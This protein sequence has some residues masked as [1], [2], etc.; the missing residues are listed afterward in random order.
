MA[1]EAAHVLV[2]DDDDLVRGVLARQLELLGYRTTAVRDGDA[3]LSALDAGGDLALLLT[4]IRLGGGHDGYA[5][6]TAAR[7]R[8]PGIAVVFM[9]GL[10][11]DDPA[12][13]GFPDAPMLTKPFRQGDLAAAL[14]AALE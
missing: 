8:R 11:D 10:V 6:A 2:V 14:A 13:A 3:A 9:T 12:A 5:L 7:R 1:P 4:D